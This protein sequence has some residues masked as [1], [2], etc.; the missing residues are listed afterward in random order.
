MP[1]DIESLLV[2][3]LTPRRPDIEVVTDLTDLFDTD[4]PLVVQVNALP[5]RSDRPAWNG[6]TLIYRLDVDVDF[7]AADRV[8]ALDLAVQITGLAAELRGT[9]DPLFGHVTEVI[10]PPASRRP[11]F[12]Q[13]IRRY[14]AVW[15]LT[16]R[17]A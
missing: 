11:D 17:P 10:A 8:A 5:S 6:P 14:G 2:Q 16:A 15:S 9:S 12:N 1:P 4:S 7:Y 3:W 13:R